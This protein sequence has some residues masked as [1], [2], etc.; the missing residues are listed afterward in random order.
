MPVNFLTDDQRRLYGRYA[1][2][3][4]PDQLAQYFHL[5]DADRK[6]IATH[7]GEHNRLGFAVQLGTVRFLGTCLENP[8]ETPPGVVLH[9]ALQLGITDLTCFAQYTGG[10]Q[11]WEHAAEIRRHYGYREFASAPVLLRLLRCLYALCWSGTDR[12]SVLFDRAI[13]WLITNKV[14][15]PGGSVLE[16]LV[17]RLRA[18]VQER[19][20][21]LLAEGL[22]VANRAALETLFAVPPG[23]RGSR[24]DRLRTGPTRCSGPE[25]AR[26]F[27]RVEE[28]RTLGLGVTIS[29]RMPRSRVLELARFAMTAKVTAIER[30]PLDRRAATLAAFV[31]TLEATA[32]DDAL[33]LFEVLLAE[34]FGEATATYEQARLRTLKDLDA[35]ALLTSAASAVLLDS[36]VPDANVRA[37]AFAQIS[38][39]ERTCTT[40]NSRPS[41]GGSGSSSRPS[42]RPCASG[43]IR[44][45]RRWRR[46]SS[47]SGCARSPDR[48]PPPTR[49]ST[50]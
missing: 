18:R 33:E 44:P 1:G 16:R 40:A 50:S 7:R 27:R 21:R 43:Q 38:R 12:P 23:E 37:V 6:L 24:L 31:Y 13:A 46:R 48:R 2:E 25:L 3:P 20:W 15:L 14:L 32:Q 5:D 8:G 47:T 17:A 10:E 39:A 36:A 22:P 30:L 35:A 11:R 26:A 4:T 45:A 41:T 49:R 42:S 28:V 29:P 34:L 19:L 9:V